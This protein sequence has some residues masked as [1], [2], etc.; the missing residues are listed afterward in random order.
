[1]F[2]TE[3][4]PWGTEMADEIKADEI[5]SIIKQQIASFSTGVTI[6]ETGTVLTVGDG[7]A[8]IYGL[9]KVMANELLDFGKGAFG[10]ALNL[11][12][13]RVG[14]VLLG[15]YL[16]I[17]QGDTVKRTNR[18]IE[19]PVGDALIGRVVNA[20]GEPVDGKGP[21]VTE[22]SN[23]IER[24]APGIADRQPVKEPLQ[25]GYEGD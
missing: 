4:H 13:D 24:I 2:D 23:P 19:V 6:S 15:D 20:L 1:M 11:E 14:A 12:E 5:S 18:I 21:I 22:S 9:E 16:G 8:T 7:I 25:T 10:L 3:I 17:Q